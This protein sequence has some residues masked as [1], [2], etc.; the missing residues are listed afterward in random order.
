MVFAIIAAILVVA[1]GVYF[2]GPIRAGL[3]QDARMTAS[4]VADPNNKT[5][6]KVVGWNQQEVSRI[7]SD[8][9]DL[10]QLP[11]GTLRIESSGGNKF[12]ILFPLDIPPKLLLF[13]VNYIQYPNGLSLDGRS[14]GVSAHVELT[15]A[16]G[17]PDPA[18]VGRSAIIYVPSDD[19]DHDLV[20][21]QIEHGST[22]RVSFQNLIW[23]SETAARMPASIGHL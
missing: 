17:V 11:V 13:L 23:E 14:I 16:F 12:Q 15:P 10:Y 5:S 20:Y 8:F 1:A 19:T 7:A 6:V 18:L 3:A 21:V 4:F 22:Y 2:F 9:T